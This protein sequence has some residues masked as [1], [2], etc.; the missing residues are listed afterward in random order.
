M[1]PVLDLLVCQAEQI[2]EL[3]ASLVIFRLYWL[4]A[5]DLKAV[6]LERFDAGTSVIHPGAT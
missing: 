6:S 2:S 3:F 5:H 1:C 4:S